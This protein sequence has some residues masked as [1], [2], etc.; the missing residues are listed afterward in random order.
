MDHAPGVVHQ[1]VILGAEILQNNLNFFGQECESRGLG[2][3]ARAW[4]KAQKMRRSRHRRQGGMEQEQKRRRS[5]QVLIVP[6]ESGAESAI[7]VGGREL[8]N[9]FRK[10]VPPEPLSLLTC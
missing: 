4:I 10:I 8:E 5:V 9:A 2:E 6:S 7:P 3:S 1:G